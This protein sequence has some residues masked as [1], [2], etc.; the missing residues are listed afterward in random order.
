MVYLNY[1]IHF[2]ESKDLFWSFLFL[3]IVDFYELIYLLIDTA[4]L[5]LPYNI[6]NFTAN[7]LL[8]LFQGLVLHLHINFCNYMKWYAL[9]IL[10]CSVSTYLLCWCYEV[11]GLILSFAGTYVIS[12][13]SLYEGPLCVTWTILQRQVWINFKDCWS[14]SKTWS[15]TISKSCIRYSNF[16]W[17][18]SK[19]TNIHY[20]FILSYFHS[21][22]HY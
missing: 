19:D 5:Q 10:L 9:S 15:L 16:V 1:F 21:F 6:L 18:I 20:V 11:T 2:I 14:Y 4:I 13:I 7:A 3:L 22:Q 12:E 8:T 17:K